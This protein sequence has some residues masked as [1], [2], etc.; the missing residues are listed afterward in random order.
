MPLSSTPT[1]ASGAASSNCSKVEPLAPDMTGSLAGCIRL[2]SLVLAQLFAERNTCPGINEGVSL[3]RPPIR[4]ER[5]QAD[6]DRPDPPSVGHSLMPTCICLAPTARRYLGASAGHRARQF[7]RSAYSSST[8]PLSSPAL[9]APIRWST[10]PLRRRAFRQGARGVAAYLGINKVACGRLRSCAEHDR[11]HAVDALGTRI[12]FAV[13]GD[14][15]DPPQRRADRGCTDQPSFLPD[16]M[17][18]R[19]PVP[20]VLLSRAG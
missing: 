14:T 3:M 10:A 18:Q 12:G 1:I 9:S 16:P 4:G 2:K 17:L 11:R 13:G 15:E 19:S 5:R 7:T 20:L 6:K 8:A